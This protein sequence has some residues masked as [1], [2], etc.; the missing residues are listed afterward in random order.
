ML[1]LKVIRDWLK[2]MGNHVGGKGKL[3]LN[4][5]SFSQSRT[6]NINTN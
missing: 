6:P 1:L 5:E 2:D 3:I 4:S